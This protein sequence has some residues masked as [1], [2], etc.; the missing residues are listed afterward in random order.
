VAVSSHTGAGFDKLLSVIA[1][2]KAEYAAV[3]RPMCEQ[4]AKDRQAMKVLIVN[5]YIKK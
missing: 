2:Q 4:L 3:Y 1:E 5:C